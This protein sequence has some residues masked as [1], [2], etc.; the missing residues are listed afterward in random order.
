[1]FFTTTLVLVFLGIVGVWLVV[2]S[3]KHNSNQDVLEADKFEI[4]E[5]FG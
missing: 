4:E 2:G 3:E 5:I 1:M